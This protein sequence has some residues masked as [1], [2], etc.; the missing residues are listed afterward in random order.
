MI[1]VLA[2]LAWAECGLDA[3][4]VDLNCDGIPAEDASPIDLG[5]PGCDGYDLG[6]LDDHFHGYPVYACLVPTAPTDVDGDGLIAGTV[7][8]PRTGDLDGTYRSFR[9]DN[10]PALAN[11]LQED[12]DCDGV[13][14]LC[15]TCPDI[16]NSGQGDADGDG[17]GDECD[18]C[19]G[20]FNPDQRDSDGDGIGDACPG[21]DRLTGSRAC[22]TAP[23]PTTGV[24][25]WITLVLLR[26]RR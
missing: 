21:E 10:C 6:T 16:E 22:A 14:D 19:P 12:A 8:L 25:A 13:G 17:V 1:L 18:N 5:R 15:D 26:R 24:L 3:P 4:I 7:Q 11:P 9:C 2:S 20:E 23:L